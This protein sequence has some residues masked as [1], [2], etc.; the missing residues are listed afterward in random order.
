MMSMIVRK[1][2]AKYYIPLPTLKIWVAEDRF[3]AVNTI[4]P[5]PRFR[6]DA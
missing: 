2:I 5:Q 4:W 1:N 3:I 6:P